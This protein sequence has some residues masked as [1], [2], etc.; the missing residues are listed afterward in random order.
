MVEVSFTKNFERTL[1]NQLDA[2][3]NMVTGYVKDVDSSGI[4]IV[5]LMK[6]MKAVGSLLEVVDIGSRSLNVNVTVKTMMAKYQSMVTKASVRLGEF[7][8]NCT[9][10]MQLHMNGETQ[11]FDFF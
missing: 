6:Q 2:D 8:S 5:K 10:A 11:T 7:S 9:R 4:N 3:F 1:R